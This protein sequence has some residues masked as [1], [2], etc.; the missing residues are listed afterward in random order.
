MRRVSSF[1]SQS[2]AKESELEKIFL[3]IQTHFA[4]I[5]SLNFNE[6]KVSSLLMYS[7]YTRPKK[8]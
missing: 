2:S 4:I 3:S 7:F 1:S 6:A 5:T 8:N